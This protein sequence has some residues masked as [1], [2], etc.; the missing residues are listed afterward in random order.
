MLKPCAIHRAL[1]NA[2]RAILMS[3]DRSIDGGVDQYDLPV[4]SVLLENQGV[5]ALHLIR[6]LEDIV[7][8]RPTAVIPIGD[9]QISDTEFPWRIGRHDAI[10]PHR[11]V[12]VM[13]VF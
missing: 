4:I 6:A 13:S 9:P 5:R 12:E 1:F 3:H 2:S 10:Y 7:E 11:C 8:T